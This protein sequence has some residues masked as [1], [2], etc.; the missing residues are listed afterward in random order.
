MSKHRNKPKRKK[1][2]FLTKFR[3]KREEITL[4]CDGKINTANI[5]EKF[6]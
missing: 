2:Q 6:I 5:H 3:A 4:K 1:M